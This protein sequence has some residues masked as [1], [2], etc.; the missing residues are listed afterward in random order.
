M[1]FENTGK[2]EAATKLTIYKCQQNLGYMVLGWV[3]GV[4]EAIVGLVHN[5]P[6]EYRFS[7]IN[8]IVFF[9]MGTMPV[10]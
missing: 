2:L 1:E 7:S 4:Q 9:V 5:H 6:S 3:Q 10:I 8:E